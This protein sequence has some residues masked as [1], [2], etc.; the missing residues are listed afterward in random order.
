MRHH[1][2]IESAGAAVTASK[3]K[4]ICKVSDH[5]R[6]HHAVASDTDIRYDVIVMDDDNIEWYKNAFDYQG[7]GF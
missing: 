5:Y 6:K 4:T 1:G 3:Q 7:Y 2:G